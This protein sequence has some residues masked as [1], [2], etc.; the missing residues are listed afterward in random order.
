MK[1]P[2]P[3]NVETEAIE[4]KTVSL[5]P[6]TALR[7]KAGTLWAAGSTVVGCA[8]V[9]TVFIVRMEGK[10]DSSL[11]GVK[12][13]SEQLKTLAPEHAILWDWYT[14]TAARASAPRS[15]P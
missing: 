12:E 3:S 10:V 9:C 4:R 8:I 15:Q 1:H 7:I 11:A 13:I 2:T 6:E 5:S 14:R